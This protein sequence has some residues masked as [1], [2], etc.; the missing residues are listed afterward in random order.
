MAALAPLKIT[1]Y[2]PETYEPRGEFIC[3]FVKLKYLK[4]AVQLMN[5]QISINEDTLAG[6]I[7]E[8]FGYQFS[9]GELMKCSEWK[10]RLAMLQAIL[11]RG[12]FTAKRKD[13]LTPDPGPSGEK[14]GVYAVEDQDWIQELTVTLVKAFGWSL[15][16]LDDTDIETLMPFVGHFAGARAR[17]KVYCDEV[18]WL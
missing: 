10:D 17:N 14:E 4:L 9:I 2:D 7:V 15:R 6:L 12:G 18:N 8:L 16:E 11:L 13:S 5:S 3:N 1:L